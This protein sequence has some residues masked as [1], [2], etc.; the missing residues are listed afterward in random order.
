MSK[1]FDDFL[2]LLD[3]L[4]PEGEEA[5]EMY[6][7]AVASGKAGDLVKAYERLSLVL[8]GMMAV[9]DLAGRVRTLHEASIRGWTPPQHMKVQPK[10]DVPK[11]VFQ[12]ALD[13]LYDREPH[14]TAAGIT[15]AEI[16]TTWRDNGFQLGKSCSVEIAKKVRDTMGRI[17]AHPEYNSV[18]LGTNIIKDISGAQW[19]RSYA[20]NV[21]RTTGA[22]C[23]SAGRFKQLSD[24]DVKHTIP[25]LQFSAVRDADVRPNHAAAHGLIAAV[26]DPIWQRL[27][28]PL[29]FN[30]RCDLVLKD[31]FELQKHGL[32]DKNGQVI[33]YLPYSYSE[34]HP[35]P[36]FQS[37][38]PDQRSTYAFK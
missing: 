13:A 35:D 10:G 27:S 37:G 29:G 6:A 16:A 9:A 28:P 18:E 8:G 30:C 7:L 25:G 19:T 24:P 3:D 22:T 20:E 15:R 32:L 2:R 12:E 33:R 26:D 5:V 31:R 14:A 23:Y 34:A 1:R 4:T 11:V 21:F 38:R 17:M 36:G